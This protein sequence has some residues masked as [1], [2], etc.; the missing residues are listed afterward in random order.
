[1]KVLV[2]PEFTQDEK[3]DQIYAYEPASTS[4]CCGGATISDN[5][6]RA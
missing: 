2:K 6:C 3:L 4:G 5:S 1:M